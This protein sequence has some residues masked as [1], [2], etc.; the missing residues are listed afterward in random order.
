VDAVS[1][2]FC[3]LLVAMG[4]HSTSYLASNVAST[5]QVQI[6]TPIPSRS[7]TPTK[8]HLVQTFL[9]LLLSYTSLPGFYGADEEESEMTLGFWYLFQEAIWSAACYVDPDEEDG[10]FGFGSGSGKAGGGVD[11]DAGSMCKAVY[12]ELV[13]VLRRKVR[14][15]GDRELAGWAKGE[16]SF[17]F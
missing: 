9:K 3:K 2:S 13:G 5:A 14:W 4:D 7:T 17:L 8:G 15:P 11:T 6:Q 12:A 1:H 16:S 10:G